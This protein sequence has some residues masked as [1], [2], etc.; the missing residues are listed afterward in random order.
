MENNTVEN[1][2]IRIADIHLLADRLLKKGLSY[3]AVKD[4]VKQRYG[5]Y[6]EDISWLYLTEKQLGLHGGLNE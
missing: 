2:L 4:A 3:E 1:N 5:N 6:G